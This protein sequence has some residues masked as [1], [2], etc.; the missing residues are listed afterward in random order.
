MS[1]HPS[2]NRPEV[3]TSD[4][5]FTDAVA[6]VDRSSVAAM[7]EEW[8]AEGVAAP[9]GPFRGALPYMVQS[10]LVALACLLLRPV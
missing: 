4:S 1:I 2:I 7:I 8:R 6:I 10:V 9:R 5:I 3:H